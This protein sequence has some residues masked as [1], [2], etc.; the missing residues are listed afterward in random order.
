[1]G[2][3]GEGKKEIQIS[4]YGMN[5]I[6]RDKRYSIGSTIHDIIIVLYS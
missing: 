6:H 4:N 5:K 1:M 2:K 3:R